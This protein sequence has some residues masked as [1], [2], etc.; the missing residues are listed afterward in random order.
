MR[1]GRGP[2]AGRRSAAAAPAPAAARDR[3]GAAWPRLDGA[4]GRRRGLRARL[5][6]CLSQAHW[7]G[8]TARSCAA[9][10][11]AAAAAANLE[12]PPRAGLARLR[13]RAGGP[14]PAAPA[15]SL[16]V[17]PLLGL[18]ALPVR[19]LYLPHLRD[20]VGRLDQLLARPVAGKHDVEAAGLRRT[21]SSTSSMPTSPRPTA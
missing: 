15:G 8:W 20:K 6:A 17:Y 5:P 9:A 12:P 19:V 10:A 3:L 7:R 21:A 14:W 2:G 18:D 16:E 11:P 13:R 4:L 1:M